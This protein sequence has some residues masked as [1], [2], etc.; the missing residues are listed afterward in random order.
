MRVGAILVT[1]YKGY[2]GTKVTETLI[3]NNLTDIVGV[4][5]IDGCDIID[6]DQLKTIFKN[7]DIKTVVHTAALK[8]IS[9]SFDYPNEYYQTNVTGTKNLLDLSVEHGVEK[10]INISSYTVYGKC[11]Y[12][13]GTGYVETQIHRPLNPY[14]IYKSMADALVT[15]YNS[16][17]NLQTINLRL[18]ALYG[19][20]NFKEQPTIN[21]FVDMIKRD[22][23]VTL[24]N[25]GD[26]LIDFL[27][28]DD[29]ALVIYKIIQHPF[30]LGGESFNVCSHD[31]NSLTDIVNL[32]GAITNKTPNI[33]LF[34][35]TEPGKVNN[36]ITHS[37]KLVNTI[38]FSPMTLRSG[39]LKML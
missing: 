15:G 29:A 13:V 12:P 17:Y 14:S 28:V 33:Q 34:A 3:K 35:N 10:F 36:V 24:Y 30:Y 5:I 11:M 25:N 2:L 18:H 23:C 21:K 38:N 7:N 22:E 31:F 6:Y 19:L 8:N 4:D 39:L 37:H 27:H 16:T 20:G 9:K 26:Q 1:G 32:I